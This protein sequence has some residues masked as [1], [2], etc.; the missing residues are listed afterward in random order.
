MRKNTPEQNEMKRLERNACER[1]W[2]AMLKAAHICRGCN[3]TD[4]YTLNGR[5][6]CAECAAKN[7]AAKQRW[8]ERHPNIE[9]ERQLERRTRLKNEGK[10][11]YCGKQVSDK[12][13]NL[14]TECRVK[15]RNY[16]AS[17]RTT[18]YPRGENGI[19]WQCNKKP[20]KEGFNLCPECYEKKVEN[21]KILNANRNNRDHVWRKHYDRDRQKGQAAHCPGD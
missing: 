3:Q 13:F 6:Y 11:P 4:A 15:Q 7:A 19:C 12:R 21:C 10:C 14:C 2:R 9:A 16:K 1:E 17:V 20:V 8:R 18:N 5:T